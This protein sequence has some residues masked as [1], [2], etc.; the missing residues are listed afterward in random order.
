MVCQRLPSQPAVFGTGRAR[1]TVAEARYAPFH[2]M[3]SKECSSVCHAPEMIGVVESNTYDGIC[4][5]DS[6][7]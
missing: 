3:S 2:T 7:R 4:C 6:P 1:H 5:A